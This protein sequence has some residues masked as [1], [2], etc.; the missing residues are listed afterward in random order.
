M[1]IVRT[2]HSLIL[3]EPQEVAQDAHG[4]D[5]SSSSST[6]D[7]QRPLTIAL[8]MEHDNVI[9]SSK[10]RRE[11]VVDIVSLSRIQY[12]RIVDGQS[13]YTHFSSEA[14]IVFVVTSTTPTYLRTLPSARASARSLSISLSNS[15]RA[16][17]KSSPVVM[18]LRAGGTR[19]FVSTEM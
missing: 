13:A 4:S 18:F 9:R 1:L 8:G 19:L 5:S 11:G 3:R 16:L 7:N 14:F 10:G 17:M 6:L 15:G 2:Y 12:V